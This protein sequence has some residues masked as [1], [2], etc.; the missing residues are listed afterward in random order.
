MHEYSIVDSIVTSML[1]A[2]EKR[3]AGILALTS[4]LLNLRSHNQHPIVAYRFHR[5]IPHRLLS[6][7]FL[8]QRLRLFEDE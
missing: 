8:F 2:I 3:G 5:A 6:L 1:N 7:A 4:R